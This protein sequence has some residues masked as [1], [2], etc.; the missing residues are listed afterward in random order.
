MCD[1]IQ[2]YI[3]IYICY[4]F[5]FFIGIFGHFQFVFF[6]VQYHCGTFG[7]PVFVACQCPIVAGRIEI[8]TFFGGAF[9][10]KSLIGSCALFLVELRDPIPLCFKNQSAAMRSKLTRPGVPAATQY[11][12]PVGWCE[13][14]LFA[15]LQFAA[16]RGS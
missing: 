1:K 7:D 5:Y 9:Q 14:T 15:E 8:V 2:Q 10:F 13:I 3:Y 6:F 12:C 4:V 11:T 16:V